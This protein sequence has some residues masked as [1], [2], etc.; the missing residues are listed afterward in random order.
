MAEGY[1]VKPDPFTLVERT[2]QAG[3]GIS[4]TNPSGVAGDSTIS[5]SNIPATAIQPGTVSNTEFGYLDGVTS[6]I[7]TQLNSKASLP[8]SVGDLPS[9]IPATK[10][11]GGSVDDTEFSYLDGATSS[12]Q[13]QLD[14]KLGVF[15][16]TSQ[17]QSYASP[18]GMSGTPAFRTLTANDI[19]NLNASKIN[20]GTLAVARIPTGSPVST[21]TANSAGAASS[22][23]LSDHVH[24]DVILQTL[25]AEVTADQTT[26]SSTLVDI[27]GASITFN[28]IS[29][30]SVILINV[31]FS[32]SNSS[33]LG[34]INRIALLIDGSIIPGKYSA[35][36]TPLIS[37]VVQGGSIIH[38]A[39]GLAAGSHTIKLQ[40]SNST[41]TT[42]CRPVTA[43]TTESCSITLIESRL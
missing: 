2:L 32:M 1:V 24:Q 18:D 42:Q 40:W 14:G 17:N 43:S 37:N 20:A 19:P 39:T 7:Q 33:A 22:V 10:I 12:I 25:S 4:I 3:T 5:V 27:T 11:A 16:S 31:S 13:T 9:N 28:K 26:T 21:G 38:R 15:G 30:S 29:A 36:S 41:G 35:F 8:V 6:S 23:A 34:S